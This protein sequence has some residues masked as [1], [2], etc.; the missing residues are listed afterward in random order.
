MAIYLGFGLRQKTECG[1]VDAL[2]SITVRA[3]KMMVSD[4]ALLI[5]S[6]PPRSGAT[7]AN[8]PF[9]PG[10]PV[11]VVPSLL[12][13]EPAKTTTSPGADQKLV[14]V[15]SVVLSVSRSTAAIDLA[16]RSKPSG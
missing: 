10:R 12:R 3:I 11:A 7:G 8:A 15:K 13:V 1:C 9:V 6:P 5:V 14:S 4:R 2:G 16:V